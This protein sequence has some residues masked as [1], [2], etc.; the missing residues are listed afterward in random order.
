MF[1]ILY[2]PSSCLLTCCLQQVREWSI[3]GLPK[4]DV[5]IDNGILVTRGRRWP[6]MIDPQ[7]QAYG[8]IKGMEGRSG[9]QSLR[10]TSLQLLRTLEAALRAGQPLILEVGESLDPALQPLLL[11]QVTLTYLIGAGTAVYIHM[12]NLACTKGRAACVSRQG[13]VRF[14]NARVQE[15]GTGACK[16]G[17]CVHDVC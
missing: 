9:L 12:P 1:R 10:S 8:W 11:K 15:E 17:E 14:P 13:R 16:T 2:K 3:W 6:L 4:D 5:S 7:S